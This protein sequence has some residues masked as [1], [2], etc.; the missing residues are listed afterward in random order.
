MTYPQPDDGSAEAPTPPKMKVIARHRAR[1]PPQAADVI[2]VP[3]LG[4]IGSWGRGAGV[5]N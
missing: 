5:T 1:T 4:V 3:S 2:C